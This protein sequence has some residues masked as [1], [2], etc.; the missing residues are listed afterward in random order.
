L[1]FE[2]ESR[3]APDVRY[4]R[5]SAIPASADY[6]DILNPPRVEMMAAT[7]PAEATRYLKELVDFQRLHAELLLRGR[8][9]D[10]RGFELKADRLIAKA[11]S[12]GT[13]LGVLI[14]NPGD[15]PAAFSLAVPD[16]QLAV[17]AEPGPGKVEPF[18]PIPPES[19]RLLVWQRHNP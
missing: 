14:W 15:K 8:F 12:A 19:L 17:A 3:Y 7:P 9:E 4:L 6:A 13:Q 2:L 16:A 18:A 11:Y 5:E 10:D 1:R